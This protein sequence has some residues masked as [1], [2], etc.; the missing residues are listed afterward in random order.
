MKMNV[1]KARILAARM[2]TA[3]TL[4][5][6]ILAHVLMD[7]EEMLLASVVT[8]TNAPSE[9]IPALILSRLVLTTLALS[10][11]LVLLD[12]RETQAVIV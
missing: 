2:K 5:D 3:A 10:T 11:A 7:T 8:L 12:T 9:A 1:L 4:M 6:R